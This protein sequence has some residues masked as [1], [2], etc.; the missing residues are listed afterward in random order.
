MS[1]VS[2]LNSAQSF[3]NNNQTVDSGSQ[4]QYQQ[5]GFTLPSTFAADGKRRI[6]LSI[7]LAGLPYSKVPSYNPGVI[8]RNIITLFVPEFGLVR[9]YVNPNNITYGNKKAISKERTKGGFNLQYWG[10][11]LETL[12][13]TGNTG[14]SGV[15][16]INML[17]E[18]YRAEQYA[19][20]SVG[21]SL[22]A[23]NASADLSN[24]L[25]NGAGGMLGGALGSFLGNI[26]S[27]PAAGAGLLGGILGLDS[28]NNRLAAQNIPSLAQLAFTV[29]MY[30]DG[31]V[32]RGFFEDM[33]VTESADNFLWNYTIRYTV[34]QRRGR[35]NNYF[36]FHKTP[37]QG[38]SQYN[39]P[40]SFN[41]NDIEF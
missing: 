21:L 10:E 20:D 1:I 37:T 30:Y 36:P 11:E 16:G 5:D 31:Q 3:I 28:P 17:Y 39:T 35:R 27:A 15:E 14:S 29:E 41:P 18:I 19:F 26:S 38:P 12:N 24:N 40:N 6:N 34:T 9:M 23:N 2:A 22:E 13:I 4:N 33:Q 7:C 32:F 25:I 8:R